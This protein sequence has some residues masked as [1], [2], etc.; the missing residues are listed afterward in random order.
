MIYIIN[1][2]IYNNDIV[3]LIADVR[4]DKFILESMNL[5]RFQDLVHRVRVEGV[6]NNFEHLLSDDNFEKPLLTTSTKHNTNLQSKSLFKTEKLFDKTNICSL[7]AYIINAGLEV[8]STPKNSDIIFDIDFNSINNIVR[9]NHKDYSIDAS[10][11]LDIR[12]TAQ[13]FGTILKC[14]EFL[15]LNDIQ[16]LGNHI[17]I[18]LNKFNMKTTEN[19]LLERITKKIL[20][21]EMKR[22]RE[23]LDY[24]RFGTEL[25]SNNLEVQDASR[26]YKIYHTSFDKNITPEELKEEVRSLEFFTPEQCN[27]IITGIDYYQEE[28]VIDDEKF[29]NLYFYKYISSEHCFL[30]VISFIL[31][32][33]T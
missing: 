7:L 11:T 6:G 12:G 24:I 19:R 8:F 5:D 31:R 30:K 18:S 20:T 9:I 2:A 28:Y 10:D 21:Q 17:K 15:D 22:L 27:F 4:Y 32:S 3:R 1:E 13:T 25:L 23:Q 33:I 14:F 16:L 26:L 29:E